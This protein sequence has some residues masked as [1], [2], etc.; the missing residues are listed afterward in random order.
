MNPTVRTYTHS[1]RS[2]IAFVQEA[3]RLYKMKSSDIAGQV[4]WQISHLQSV[5]K[6]IRAQTGMSLDNR[7]VLVIGPG[8]R[9]GEV[10]YFGLKNRVTAIDLDVIM[11]RMTPSAALQM[12]KANGATRTVKTLGRKALGLDDK[13]KSQMMKQ[14]DV[15]KMPPIRHLQMDATEM[16][17]PDRSVDF[18]FSFSVFEHIPDPAKCLQEISRVLKPGGVCY[19]SLHLYSC[20]SG[21]HDLRIW[22]D[23]ARPPTWAHLRPQHEAEVQ[24]NAYMNKIRLHDWKQMLEAH[25]PDV[26]FTTDKLEQDG[27]EKQCRELEHLRK[28][29]ELMDYTDEELHAINLVSIWQ[30]PL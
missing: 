15:K 16:T 24:P 8:Q 18:V 14:T 1:P 5:E 25:S 11:H 30:K 9:V 3:M 29:G 20:D 27:Y 7:E 19:T 13:F 17:L 26:T 23:G 21:C 10:F 22:S 6:I 28:S 4:A 2:P 12:W